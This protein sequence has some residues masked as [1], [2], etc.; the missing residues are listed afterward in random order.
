MYIGQKNTHFVSGAVMQLLPL[1]YGSIEFASNKNWTWHLTRN[2]EI[3]W[4]KW[5][6]VYIYKKNQQGNNNPHIPTFLYFILSARVV[7]GKKGR[8]EQNNCSWGR[9]AGGFCLFKDMKIMNQKAQR[10]QID[11]NNNNN[12]MQMSSFKS[13]ILRSIKK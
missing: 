5:H 10:S 7:L 13:Q 3:T 12:K 6:F 8:P 2:W 1:V 4:I 11:N 9:K